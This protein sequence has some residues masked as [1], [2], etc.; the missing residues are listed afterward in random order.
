MY[1]CDIIFNK[2]VA[3][4]RRK[5]T[6]YGFLM[7]YQVLKNIKKNSE[8]NK[9]SSLIVM[10]LQYIKNLRLNFFYNTIELYGK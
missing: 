10:I 6:K 4:F 3:K 7:I 8:K 5:K 9:P 2:K 1:V